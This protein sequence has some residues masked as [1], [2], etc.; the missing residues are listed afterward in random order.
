M[1]P[2]FPYVMMGDCKC[3]ND[4]RYGRYVYDN[5]DDDYITDHD[6]CYKDRSLAEIVAGEV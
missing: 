4:K 2:L 3:N 6:C 5:G 1:P